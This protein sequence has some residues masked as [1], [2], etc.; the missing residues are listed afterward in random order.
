MF[1]GL[2]RTRQGDH[3]FKVNLGCSMFETS[4]SYVVGEGEGEKVK[5][6]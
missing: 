2:R 6:H 3:K 5:C 1:L 4:L